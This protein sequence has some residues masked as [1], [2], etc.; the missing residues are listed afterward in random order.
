MKLRNTIGLLLMGGSVWFSSCGDDAPAKSG[1]SFEVAT[2]FLTESDATLD[3]FHP[4]LIEDA[5]GQK[6]E[7]K[8]LFD[9]PLQQNAVI[10]YSVGGTAT[11]NST[12]NPVGD[13]E[14]DGNG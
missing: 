9:K 12:A 4:L 7:V 3:S 11:Q 14:I 6:V 1:V 5:V 13:F 2:E 10:A 8:I